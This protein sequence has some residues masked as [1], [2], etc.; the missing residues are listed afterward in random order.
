MAKSKSSSGSVTTWVQIVVSAIGV[1]LTYKWLTTPRAASSLPGGFVGGNYGGGATSADGQSGATNSLLQ[2]LANLLNGKKGGGGGVS[3]GNGGAGGAKG[4]ALP[5]SLANQIAAIGGFSTIA[6]NTPLA[7]L[8]G[9]SLDTYNPALFDQS[10]IAGDQIAYEPTSLFDL[11]GMAFDPLDLGG[12]AGIPL[13]YTGVGDLSIPDEP[14][15]NFD[16]SGMDF[17]PGGDLATVPGGVN[18][19]LSDNFG[20]FDPSANF[21]G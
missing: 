16:L 11:G 8:G 9:E 2:K 12:G 19:G 17:G 1:Y 15:Q 13:D 7:E 21:F 14:L 6:N 4:T 10:L 18:S 20:G 5:Q 3:L